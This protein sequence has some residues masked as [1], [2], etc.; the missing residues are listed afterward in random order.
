MGKSNGYYLTSKKKQFLVWNTK[1]NPNQH[2][3]F[4]CRD[5]QD[6]SEKLLRKPI[7]SFDS[8]YRYE[9]FVFFFVL[10]FVQNQREITTIDEKE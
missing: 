10:N 8:Y 3:S 6:S 2:M 9:L 7:V 1:K 4:G 5:D